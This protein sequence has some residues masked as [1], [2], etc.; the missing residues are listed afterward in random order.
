MKEDGQ[1]LLTVLR[2]ACHLSGECGGFDLLDGDAL[3]HR[4]RLVPVHHLL[5]EAADQSLVRFCCHGPPFLDGG[6]TGLH[7]VP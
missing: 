7:M 2:F 4:V 5:E 1:A 3:I 6:V